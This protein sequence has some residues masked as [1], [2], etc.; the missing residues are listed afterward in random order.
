MVDGC[1]V[2][3]GKAVGEG[4]L[5]SADYAAVMVGIAAAAVVLVGIASEG[6]DDIAPAVILG[7]FNSIW[8]KAAAPKSSRNIK[9]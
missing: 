5:H 3:M 2:A 7:R 6:N 9:A 8:A 4:A 1:V